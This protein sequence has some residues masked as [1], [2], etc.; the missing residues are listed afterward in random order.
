MGETCVLSI[1][2]AEEEITVDNT[3]ASGGAAMTGGFGGGPRGQRGDGPREMPEGE[4]PEGG[5]PEGERPEGEMPQGGGPDG[6]G[7]Q[8]PDRPEGTRPADGEMGTPPD[9][10]PGQGEL[11]QNAPA[12]DTGTVHYDALPALSVSVAILALGLVFAALLKRK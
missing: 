3:S 9:G 6:E 10:A 12:G 8:P 2:G 7:F 11:P 4:P 1:G 5:M